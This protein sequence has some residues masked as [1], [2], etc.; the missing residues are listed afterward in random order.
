MTSGRN[1]SYLR[2]TPGVF[3][4]RNSEA[5]IEAENKAEHRK[6]ST[7]KLDRR[8]REKGRAEM[9]KKRIV[10]EEQNLV[11]ILYNEHVIGSLFGTALQISVLG[12]YVTF[13][14]AI[15]RLIRVLFDRIS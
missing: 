9:Q 13:V 1:S 3:N 6:Q 11:V 14:I 7:S 8:A 10:K 12:L 4:S 5:D 15:G 2:D